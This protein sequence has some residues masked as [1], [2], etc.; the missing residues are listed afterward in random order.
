MIPV[1]Y[2]PDAQEELA[3]SVRYYE[4]RQTGHFSLIPT[5]AARDDLPEEPVTPKRSCLGP[6]DRG[7]EL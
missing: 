4:V 1:E 3:E 7:R 6:T 2:H 5:V